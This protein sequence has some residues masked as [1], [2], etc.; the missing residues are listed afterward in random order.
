MFIPVISLLYSF[1]STRQ[2]AIA[3]AQKELL[4]V[5]YLAPLKNLYEHMP[6]HRDLVAVHLGGQGEQKDRIFSV[7]AAIDTD[8]KAL[9][10]VDQKLG[11]TLN[12]TEKLQTLSRHWQ[13]V[14]RRGVESKAAES[15]EQHTQLIGEITDLLQHVADRSNLILDPDLD[16]YYL[17]DTAVNKLP[18]TIEHLG[19][20]GGLG[21]SM[22]ARKARTIEE[23]TQMHFIA[24]QMKSS[25]EPLKRSLQVAYKER[26]GLESTMAP[27]VSK[28]FDGAENFLRTTTERVLKADPIT[29]PAA[30]YFARQG[31]GRWT[32]L[33]AVR[34]N[35]QASA[36]TPGNPPREVDGKSQ[37]AVSDCARSRHTRRSCSPGHES[38]HHQ[39]DSRR[40]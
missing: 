8:F 25:L 4:G 37:L 3:F 10:A 12:T 31:G 7:Q 24:Q 20:L 30:E 11:K 2:E 6:Q 21:S 27:V 15:F 16:T 5:E 17:M 33:D 35:P 13:E 14:K 9:E 1:L 23:Q 32:V 36:R 34:Y 40:P 28:A 38:A 22:A 39:A 18:E 29:M 19:K 26:V